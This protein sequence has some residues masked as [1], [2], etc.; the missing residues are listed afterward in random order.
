MRGGPILSPRAAIGATLSATVASAMRRVFLAFACLALAV[1]A[2]APPAAAP[3][4]PPAAEP[5]AAGR[6]A[7]AASSPPSASE[8]PDAAEASARTGRPLD[9]TNTCPK[10]IRLYY[11][12][13]PGD[14]RGAFASVGAGA[15]ATIP[16][17]ADGTVVVW[18]V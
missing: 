14:G 4:G 16:R 17:G 8:P 10:A 9:V 12:D 15:T 7:P 18:V 5:A 3:S 1:A 2:C 6:V 13:T 11:G